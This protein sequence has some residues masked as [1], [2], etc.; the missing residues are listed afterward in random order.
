MLRDTLYK[1][2]TLDQE[3]CWFTWNCLATALRNLLIFPI[4]MYLTCVTVS[5]FYFVISLESFL[6]L[7]WSE[8]ESIPASELRV[9]VLQNVF[10]CTKSLPV[11]R[12]F[13]IEPRNIVNSFCYTY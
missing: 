6:S 1:Q 4:D 5:V 12:G 9:C 3:Q 7:T 8:S 10:H 13:V 2:S 11:D